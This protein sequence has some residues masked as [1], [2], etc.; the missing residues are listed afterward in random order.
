MKRILIFAG[1]GLVVLLIAAAI[2]PFLI[3]SEVYKRQIE[4]AATNALGREVAVQGDVSL[5]IFPQI[6]ASVDG[7][8]VANP[9]GFSREHMVEAGALKGVVK[10]GPLLSRRVEVA[11]IAFVDADVML[12]RR[13][14]GAVNWEFGPAGRET[15]PDDGGAGGSVDAGIDR[16]R[17]ENARLVFDDRQSGARYEISE[18]DLEASL[19]SLADPLTAEAAGLFQGARFDVDLLLKVPQTLLDGAPATIDLSLETE[20]GALSYDGSAQLADSPILDGAFTV[21]GRDLSQLAALA[22]TDV[23][24]NLD[25]LGRVAASGTVSGAVGAARIVFTTLSLGGSGF[26]GSYTGAVNLGDAI[27]LDGRLTADSS[28]MGNWLSGL[29]L[30]LPPSVSVLERIDLSTDVSGPV[31]TLSLSGTSFSH[32][33]D[34]LDARFN[35]SARLGEASTVSGALSASSDRLRDL[36]AAADVDLAEGDTLERFQVSGNVSGSLSRIAVSGL[37]AE[38]DDISASGEL[39]LDLDGPRPALNGTLTTGVLDLS[40]FLG[41]ESQPAQ[42]GSQGWSDAPLDLTGLQAVDADLSLTAERIILG[43]ITLGAPD[44]SARLQNGDLTTTI[45]SMQAF[46]GAWQ[47]T[48]GLQS[49]PS[50]PTMRLNLT[51]QTIQ[52]SDALMSLAGLD[53][54]SGVGQLNVDVTSRGTSLKALVEGLSGQMGSNVANGAIKGINVGQL[55]RSRDSL[56]QS[57]ANGSLQMALAPEAETDF[58]SL[59]AGLTLENGVAQVDQ[60]NLTNPV[61]SL[62]GS[63]SINLGARTLDVGIVPR[64]D[65]SGQGAGSSLQLNNVPIPFRI[66]G[67]WLSPSLTPDTQMIR[68]ILRQDVETRA[69]DAIRDEVGDELGGLLEGVLGTPR[70]AWPAP[71]E[72]EPAP[73]SETEAPATEPEAETE[74]E[75][76]PTPAQRPEDVVEDLAR[77]AARDALGGLFGNRSR[78]E[79]EETPEEEEAPAPQ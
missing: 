78:E 12:E 79:P 42:S 74:P 52:L 47:G 58:T 15:A 20:G 57:L 46:G 50:V 33:G 24:L 68:S 29:G 63:G 77:E 40:P 66:R 25:A 56:L 38:L 35:G 62:E 28:N 54:L 26:D 19:Q 44:L 48:F 23:P 72:P 64:L 8:S 55:V 2:V 75:T 51:G 5:S 3:P 7:V 18:L 10:W 43:D 22:G 67:N 61:V 60:F 1:I 27:E 37:E 30:D 53:A 17:L 41:E 36:L 71:S 69:R 76:A 45:A 9:E 31:D 13:E 14:D 11:E 49:S 65:T 4:E 32:Q 70:P 21:E 73:E 6:A 39:A 34:L 59:L 16:A